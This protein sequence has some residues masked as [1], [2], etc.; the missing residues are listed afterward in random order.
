[1]MNRLLPLALPFALVL[2]A[3][4]PAPRGAVEPT[5]ADSRVAPG[6]P[7]MKMF[8]SGAVQRPSRS[9]SQIARD[10]LDLSF[11][12]ESGRNLDIFTRFE[13]PVTIRLAGTAP[14]TLTPDLDRLIARLRNEAG[15]DVSRVSGGTANITIETVPRGELQRLVVT[16]G[17]RARSLAS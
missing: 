5:R 8:P 15:I 9:N 6:L 2:A 12:L 16:N 17:R 7:P 4:G 3:C 11:N 1:M 14:A 13:G 10:F